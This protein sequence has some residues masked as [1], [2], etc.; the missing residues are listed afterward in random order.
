MFDTSS[1]ILFVGAACILA[2]IVH[3]LWFSDRPKNRKLEKDNEH[4]Q[5][6]SKSRQ[7]GKVRIVSSDLSSS[8]EASDLGSTK[9]A[10]HSNARGSKTTV[11]VSARVNLPSD[12]DQGKLDERASITVNQQRLTNPDPYGYQEAPQGYSEPQPG[13]AAPGY[14]GAA[15]GYQ[16]YPDAAAEYTP[17]RELYEIIL[18]ADRAHPYRGEDIEA[19]CAH[20]GFIQ[21]F[22]QDHYK[23]YFVYEN[24]T[25]KDAEV[26][27]ICSMDDQYY[28]PENMQGATF[29]AIA[30]YMLLPPR[31]KAFAYFKALR[32]ASEIF[33]NQLGG[34][35]EDQNRQPLTLQDLD[36]M[37]LELQ[38]YDGGRTLNHPAG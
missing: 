13:Y 9:I 10:K 11:R 34:V 5:E 22:V 19:L 16:G 1:I 3:G 12:F 20:Y 31:G 18:T 27:R 15:P 24:A 37:A 14:Q 30:L 28:F 36:Q 33:L 38:R 6:L 25:T 17:E 2:F 32:M 23:I 35:M 7:I 29:S 8:T 4:D 21:G 26:F